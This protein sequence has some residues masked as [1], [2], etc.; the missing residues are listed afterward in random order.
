MSDQAIS[1]VEIIAALNGRQDALRKIRGGNIYSWSRTIEGDLAARRLAELD[2][3]VWAPPTGPPVNG[4]PPWQGGRLL[5]R[6][7]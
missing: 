3:S 5:R 2:P 6:A 4:V 1:T 7:T